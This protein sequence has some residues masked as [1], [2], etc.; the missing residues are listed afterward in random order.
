MHDFGV[1]FIDSWHTLKHQDVDMR[2]N[3]STYESKNLLLEQ[4]VGIRTDGYETARLLSLLTP[5]ELEVWNKVPYIKKV[6]WLFGRIAAKQA[7]RNALYLDTSLEIP[8]NTITV[9]SRKNQPP[10]YRIAG[11]NLSNGVAYHVSI[12]HTTG[13][14]LGGA[15]SSLYCSGIGLDVEKI[16]DFTPLVSNAFLTEYE[17]RT[18][19]RTYGA[20]TNEALTR[21]WCLKEA[22]VKAI[23]EG[24]RMHPRNIEIHFQ[25]RVQENPRLYVYGVLV[26]AQSWWTATEDH[27]I[28]AG[29]ILP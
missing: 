18:C 17:K 3:V 9:L 16:R 14:A 28:I 29:V 7:L 25:S 22:Y 23:G 4:T 13:I 8:H 27:Y 21:Y 1:H 5:C 10:T 20:L 24:L 2:R 26:P 12:S 15:V 11:D 6:S 19:I